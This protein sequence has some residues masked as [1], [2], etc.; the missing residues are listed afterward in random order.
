MPQRCQDGSV[1]LKHIRSPHVEAPS[2][3]PYVARGIPLHHR[4]A[5]LLLHSLHRELP[6]H[7]RCEPV[8]VGAFRRV[9]HR[10]EVLRVHVVHVRGAEERQGVVLGLAVP[11]HLIDG[12][13]R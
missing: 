9:Q 3:R 11:D 6:R 4:P 7:K 2:A 13:R 8:P 10:L 5:E 1:L 12:G